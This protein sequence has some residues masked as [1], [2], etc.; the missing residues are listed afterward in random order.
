MRSAIAAVMMFSLAACGREVLSET[1]PEADVPEPAPA[2]AEPVV[3]KPLFDAV[4]LG[5]PDDPESI[6]DGRNIAETQCAICHGLGADASL[7][8]DAP[9]LRYVLARYHPNALGE[10]LR[11]GIHVG[12]EDMPDFVFGDLGADVLLAYLVSIQESPPPE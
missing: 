2:V 5:I 10:S 7:R 9:P 12:H 11:A 1:G 4:A 3:Q 8:K 6:E